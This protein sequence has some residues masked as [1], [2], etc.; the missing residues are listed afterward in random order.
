MHDR[1]DS[2]CTKI[3]AKGRSSGEQFAFAPVPRNTKSVLWCFGGIGLNT[4]YCIHLS[5]FVPTPS[6]ENQPQQTERFFLVLSTESEKHSEI[7]STSTESGSVI[8]DVVR[9]PKPLDGRL[10]S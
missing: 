4:S 10:T 9:Q 1:L 8:V 6:G 5:L 3:K 7:L 2:N